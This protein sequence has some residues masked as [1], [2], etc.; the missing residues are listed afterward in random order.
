MGMLCRDWFGSARL[1][2]LGSWMVLGT[3]VSIEIDYKSVGTLQETCF[4]SSAT[5]VPHNKTTHPLL[6]SCG[7]AKGGGVK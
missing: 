3:S 7:H 1:L 6:H 2:A 5:T 4:H